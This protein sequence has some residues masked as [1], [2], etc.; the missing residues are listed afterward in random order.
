[1]TD[2]MY[3][4][5][6][7]PG[8]GKSTLAT[9]LHLSNR[10][11]VSTDEFFIDPRRG[12]VFSPHLLGDAHADCLSRASRIWL[13]DYCVAVVN[14][15]SQRWELEPYI[16]LFHQRNNDVKLFVVDLFDGGLTDVELANR[17]THDVPAKTISRMRSRWEHDWKNGNPDQIFWWERKGNMK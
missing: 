10:L 7:L 2:T 4:I 15:F 13:D 9:S 14:T 3:L 8:S 6:G 1:M 17:T 16:K 5:R 12:F 11:V